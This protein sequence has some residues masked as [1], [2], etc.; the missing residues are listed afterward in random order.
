MPER[1]AT[2]RDLI[3]AEAQKQQVPPDLA[4]ALVNKESSGDVGA[5]GELTKSGQQARGL[6]QLLPSTAKE[7][8]VDPNDPIQNIQGGITYLR[9]QLDA[10]RD[11]NT[12]LRNVG[13]ALA[14]YH[15]GP[16]PR[17]HGPKTAA[18]VQSILGQLQGTQAVPPPPPPSS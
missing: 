14:R 16:D 18:Y 1:P 8:G 6:F 10:T 9:Q 7:L 5:T 2:Y 17:Q 12:G 13:A 3:T 15:G 11:P 4:F